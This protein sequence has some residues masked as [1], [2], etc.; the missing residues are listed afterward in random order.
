MNKTTKAF[1]GRFHEL[2]ERMT[3]DQALVQM[4]DEVYAHAAVTGGGPTE[5]S[6]SSSCSRPWKIG[7]R[8]KPKHGQPYEQRRFTVWGIDGD[9]PNEHLLGEASDGFSIGMDADLCERI[10]END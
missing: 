3:T 9:P 10:S 2:R 5:V 7:D 4:L 1:L 6:G 8:F